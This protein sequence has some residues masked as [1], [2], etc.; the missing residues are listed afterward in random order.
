MS[1]KGNFR[2]ERRYS[3]NFDTS[4]QSFWDLEDRD[5]DEPSEKVKISPSMKS[6]KVILYL[7]YYQLY[8]LK[9]VLSRNVPSIEAIKTR[10]IFTNTRRITTH[11]DI[12]LLLPTIPP[13]S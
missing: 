11:Y 9:S 8:S 5:D 2:K 6:I 12:S 13:H 10:F 7:F 3:C 4:K 1:N